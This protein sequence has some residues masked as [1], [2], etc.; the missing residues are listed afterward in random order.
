MDVNNNGK[1][2]DA[3]WVDTVWREGMLELLKN[4]REILGN[5]KI[6]MVNSSSYGANYINGRL[7]ESWPDE[8]GGGWKGQMKDYQNLEKNIKHIPQVVVLNPNT[9]NTGINNNYAQVRFGL[10]STLQGNG[11]FAF[12]WGTQDHSQLWRYDEYEID[13]GYPNSQ[14]REIKPGVLRRDFTKGVVLVNSTAQ[15]QEIDLGPGIYQ[16][17]NGFQ[18]LSLI[19]I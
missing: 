11:Y 12:D 3:N 1:L 2:D 7:Y 5:E 9:N 14:S 13:L 17:I 16:K 18:D 4:T 19:H 6:I 15:A 10:S 8:W